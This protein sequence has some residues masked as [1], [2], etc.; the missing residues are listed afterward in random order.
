MLDHIHECI[1]ILFL[2]LAVHRR[3]F[4][5]QHQLARVSDVINDHGRFGGDTTDLQ[6]YLELTHDTEYSL[7]RFNDYTTIMVSTRSKTAQTHLEDFA[8]KESVSKLKEKKQPASPTKAKPKANSSRKRKSRDAD[9][10]KEKSSPKRTKTSPKTSTEPKN[11]SAANDD[12]KPIIINRAPVLQL[13]AASVAHLTYLDLPWQTCL[14][15]G[16]A[17]SSICAVA[18]GRSIGTVPEKDDSEAKEEKREKAKKKQKNLDE[19]EVMHFKL[20]IVDG[21]AVV[22]SDSKGKPGGEDGLRKKFGEGEYEKVRSA[23]KEALES[24][25][26]EED[27]LNKKAFHMYEEFRPDVSK[28]Q[29]GWGRKGELDLDTIR[30]TVQK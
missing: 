29:K 13:W 26:G 20:K 10:T 25:K 3:R 2:H 5:L 7:R 22:G 1:S 17:V 15:A 11:E 8:T 23:F 12:S 9:D 14:S 18:K 19:V 27:E 28:G 30:S 21:L 24:W 6:V 4:F 16:S